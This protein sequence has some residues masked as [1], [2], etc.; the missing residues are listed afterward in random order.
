MNG[1]GAACGWVSTAASSSKRPASR[2]RYPVTR[3]TARGGG[4]ARGVM[5]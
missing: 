2:L 1:R 4:A 3:V 5:W